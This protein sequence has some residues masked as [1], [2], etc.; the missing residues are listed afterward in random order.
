MDVKKVKCVD[1]NGEE[2]NF[3]A[4][5]YS[6]RPSVY[7]VLINENQ[8]VLMIKHKGKYCFPGG[9][10]EISEK[11]YDALS[12]EVFEETGLRIVSGEI[13]ECDDSFFLVPYENKPVHSILMF[14]CCTFK[15][16]KIKNDNVDEFEKEY[17]EKAEWISIEKVL[18]MNSLVFSQTKRILKKIIER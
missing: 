16:G 3:S 14:Y 10:V 15:Q 1:F 2:H 13:L 5:E 12:R 11:I 6:F 7:G 17:A 4:N 9:G 18:K 8:E